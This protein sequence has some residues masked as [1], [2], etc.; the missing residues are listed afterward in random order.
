MYAIDKKT[1]KRMSEIAP[2]FGSLAKL[3]QFLGKIHPFD[4]EVGSDSRA[5][6]S[7]FPF[8]TK[9]GRNNPSKYIFGADRGMRGFIKPGPGQAVA[10]LDWERQEPAIAGYL[11]GDEALL[12][13]AKLA[14]PYIHLGVTYGLIPKGGTKDSHPDER[15]RCKSVILGAVLYGMGP[16]SIARGLEIPAAWGLAIW[17]RIRADYRVLLAMG[18]KPR[19]LG[20]RASTLADALWPYVGLRVRRDRGPQGRDGPQLSHSGDFSRGHAHR[21]H[22]RHG[23]G[24][25]CLRP[26][27]RRVSDRG[28][29]RIDRGRGR[30]NEGLHGA[31]DRARA[32]AWLRGRCRRHHHPVPRLLHLAEE[33]GVRH[34]CRGD[35]CGRGG[36]HL[37]YKSVGSPPRNL[38][39][40]PCEFVREHP[41]LFLSLFF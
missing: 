29:D 12:R 37:P 7:L 19:Q 3:R 31:G 40:Y 25:R 24:D 1:F 27:S 38:W 39:G 13:L 35:C 15:Q 2:D 23:S 26:S 17:Q 33:R 16:E 32:V 11:S 18:R 5:R 28:A 41:R 21:R 14:D 6:T 30:E 34:N 20:R 22:P 9:T 4:F 10:Y 36:K 8:G